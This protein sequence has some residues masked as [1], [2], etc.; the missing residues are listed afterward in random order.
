MVEYTDEKTLTLIF[1]AMGDT[2]RRSLLR[3]LC[4][5]GPTPVTGLA[6]HYEISLNAISKHIKALEKADLVKRKTIGRSHLIEAN[7]EHIK[8]AEQCFGELKSIWALR[9]DKLDEVLGGKTDGGT[10]HYDKK[11]GSSP[12]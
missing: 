11:N 1:K 2:T 5:H 10:I 3:Q 7:L 4:Q 12:D 8:L 9:L 6:E